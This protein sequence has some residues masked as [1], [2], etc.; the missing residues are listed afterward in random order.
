MEQYLN[1]ILMIKNQNILAT[2]MI[3]L[4]QLKT[5]MKSFIQ[6]KQTSKRAVAEL[7]SKISKKKKISNEQ[8]HDCEANMFL[9]KV[10]KS[11]N[12]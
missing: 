4:S 5:C 8:F 9:E 12:S 2:L 7:F 3:F 11:I 10:P 1:Y 6:M